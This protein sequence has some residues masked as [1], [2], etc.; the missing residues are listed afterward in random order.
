MKKIDFG[1][2]TSKTPHGS[3]EG[4]GLGMQE[5]GKNV[6][7]V[8]GDFI[9]VITIDGDDYLV[10]KVN[11]AFF[12]D[13]KYIGRIDVRRALV[14][15]YPDGS[16]I[17]YLDQADSY[18]R[19]GLEAFLNQEQNK[20]RIDSGIPLREIVNNCAVKPIYRSVLNT[21]YETVSA[22]ATAIS[23]EVFEEKKELIDHCHYSVSE[24]MAQL[25]EKGYQR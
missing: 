19:Q 15:M 25:Y 1:F 22:S 3:F 8:G 16:G 18:K 14:D 17:V 23:H 4:I 7:P 10:T 5:N 24:M 2:D 20:Q 9:D 13:P 6:G 11:M 12:N 21:G